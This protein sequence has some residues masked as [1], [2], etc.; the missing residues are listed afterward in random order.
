MGPYGGS[1]SCVTG[2]QTLKTTTPK[3]AKPP[4][5]P[6]L[7]ALPPASPPPLARVVIACAVEDGV[8]TLNDVRAHGTQVERWR[9]GHAPGMHSITRRLGTS[10]GG[11]PP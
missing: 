9:A 4:Q 6:I 7:L 2:G 5:P 1:R 3:L 8:E 11:L 10:S